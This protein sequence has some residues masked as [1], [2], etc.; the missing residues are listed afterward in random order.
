M[1]IIK[2]EFEGSIY[3]EIKKVENRDNCIAK[4]TKDNVY[5]IEAMIRTDSNYKDSEDPNKRPDQ[6]Y[7][8]FI[9]E[10]DY[11]KKP[12]EGKYCGSVSYWIN[13]LMNILKDGNEE[14]S[15]GYNYQEVIK[16]VVYSI[17]RENRTHLN[18]DNIGRRTVVERICKIDKKQ[19]KEYLKD[20]RKNNYELI[21]IISATK[22]YEKKKE[23]GEHYHFSFATK[24]CHYLCLKLWE[25]TD[26]ED[27]FSIYDSVL[28]KALPIYIKEYLGKDI[29]EDVYKNNYLKYIGYIDKIRKNASI[30]YNEKIISRNG[31]DHL[32]WYY[33]KGRS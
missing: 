10:N 28:S 21:D 32:V 33:H 9:K 20:P 24:F 1:G 17:D 19:L 2:E 22:E 12:P 8:N 3:Y 6:A 26:Y 25:N 13:Q 11:N 29:K 15:D 16:G 30:R 14:T 4:L 7:I 27:N 18:S 23:K 5:R 31:F